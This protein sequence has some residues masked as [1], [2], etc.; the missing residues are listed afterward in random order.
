MAASSW[1][2]TVA[3]TPSRRYFDVLPLHR[4]SAQRSMVRLK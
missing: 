3:F 2:W 1:S 4:V